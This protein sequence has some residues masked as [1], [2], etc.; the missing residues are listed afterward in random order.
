MGRWH[1][2]PYKRSV[3][4]YG[5]STPMSKISK[6]SDLNESQVAEVWALLEPLVQAAITHRLHQFHDALLSRDQI[7]AATSPAD[8]CVV[9][10]AT[11]P[12]QQ[13]GHVEC[14]A[15]ADTPGSNPLPWPCAKLH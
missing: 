1:P 12:G 13:P 8:D 15:A 4:H 10:A 11:K 2:T 3:R 14:S 5:A 9:V 6:L 7:P